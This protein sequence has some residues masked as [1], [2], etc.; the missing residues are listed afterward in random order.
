MNGLRDVLNGELPEDRVKAFIEA[1]DEYE[2]DDETFITF[3]GSYDWG[4]P[5]A[6]KLDKLDLKDMAAELDEHQQILIDIDKAL[7]GL[8]TK[9]AFDVLD[10]IRVIM[11]RKSYNKEV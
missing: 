10:A 2:G 8:G 1:H 11:G 9:S 4:S 7:D 3:T 6:V 5:K